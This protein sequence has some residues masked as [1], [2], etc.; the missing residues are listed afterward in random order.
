MKEGDKAVLAA[1]QIEA[2]T[3]AK[4]RLLAQLVTDTRNPIESILAMNQL[5]LE[6]GSDLTAEQQNYVDGIQ[7]ATE[8]LAELF[9]D[10]NNA[11]RPETNNIQLKN[12]N[13]NVIDAIEPVVALVAQTLRYKEQDLDLI[14]FVDPN[15]PQLTGDVVRFKQIIL[16]LVNTNLSSNGVIYISA[17]VA[18]DLDTKIQLKMEIKQIIGD[19]KP[20]DQRTQNISYLPVDEDA[21]GLYIAKQLVNTMGGDICY[22]SPDENNL[23]CRLRLWFKKA[24]PTSRD[25]TTSEFPSKAILSEEEYESTDSSED[26]STNSSSLKS[27]PLSSNKEAKIL[28]VDPLDVV[29]H[30]ISTY[31]RTNPNYTCHTATSINEAVRILTQSFEMKNPFDLILLDFKLETLGRFMMQ[32]HPKCSKIPNGCL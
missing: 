1:K 30:G 6:T 5:L 2:A 4:N 19:H 25:I 13:F 32:S 31:L 17:E 27:V 16:N 15:I 9:S 12:E 23:I 22:N 29:V 26:E 14:S 18:Q 8:L 7:M 10:L 20:K 11:S 28:I 21:L 3:N 24:V